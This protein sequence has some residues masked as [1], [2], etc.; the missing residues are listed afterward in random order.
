M[1]IVL[2][3]A[4]DP[5]LRQAILAPLL[6]YNERFTGVLARPVILAV[7]LRDAG[8]R[9][10]GG[11]IGSLW[12]RWFKLDIAFVP[13]H[14]RGGGLGARIL[15]TLEAAAVGRGA[16]G[17]WMQSYSFQAPGFY[18]KLGYREIARLAD[19]P[20]GFYDSFLVKTAGFASLGAELVVVESPDEEDSATL[21]A[22]LMAYTDGHAGANDWRELFLTVRDDD[23]AVL[24]G[25]YGR[26]GRGWLFIELLGLPDALRHQRIGSE[27]MARAEAE[28]RARGC[29]GVYIDTFSFQA[30]PFYEKHGYTVFAEITDYPPGHSRFF[31]SKRLDI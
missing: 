6:A 30:R 11:M 4:K 31:L 1:Q 24:G 3:D 19:R 21:G 26:S 9:I 16:V 7:L 15:S 29:I 13:P 23:G 8:G 18:Q 12:G 5:P 28:A 22:L 14:R 17:V 27:L 25:L 20:P 10:E 2:T